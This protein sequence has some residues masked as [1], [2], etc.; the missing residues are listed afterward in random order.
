MSRATRN[1]R[2]AQVKKE[3]YQSRAEIWD[4]SE[5]LALKEAGAFMVRLRVDSFFSV[6]CTLLHCVYNYYH[7]Y[8][9]YIQRHKEG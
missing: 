9:Y 7:Y 4:S 1:C 6:C 3:L 8:Y 5:I 2:M